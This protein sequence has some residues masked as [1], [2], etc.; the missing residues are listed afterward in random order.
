[1]VADL[2]GREKFVQEAV[3][4]AQSAFDDAD[5]AHGKTKTGLEATRKEAMAAHRLADLLR[6]SEELAAVQERLRKAEAADQNSTN[7]MA[8]A[9]ASS[10]TST[11][12][13][14]LRCLDSNAREEA[15]QLNAVATLLELTPDE[16]RG[17]AIQGEAIEAD[18]ITLIEPT[19]IDLEGYGAIRVTPGGEDLSSRREAAEAAKTRLKLELDRHG[20]AGV[21]DAVGQAN[22]REAWLN[23]AAIHRTTV[24]AHA[25]EG[26][27]ALRN[28]VATLEV[29]VGRIQEN[30]DD[31]EIPDITA[32]EAAG[33]ADELAQKLKDVET[34]EREASD[35]LKDAEGTLQTKK[36]LHSSA[37]S[38]RDLAE[39]RA[40][41][42]RDALH[43]AANEDKDEDLEQALHDATEAQQAAS[44]EVDKVETALVESDPD[45]ARRELEAADEARDK[46]EANFR[47][48]RQM[49]RDLETELRAV[50][51]DDMAAEIEVAEGDLTRAKVL[52]ARLNHEGEA[53]TLLQNTLVEEEQIARETFLTPVRDRIKPYLKRLFPG[54]EL[55]LDDQTLKITH[56]RREGQDEPY[57]QLSIGTRE[58]LAVLA[59]LA[60]AD[61]LD[62]HGKKSPIILD[63]ALVFSD[64]QRFEE[65]Q[66]IL[67]RAAERLQILVLTCHERAYFDRGWTT[68]RLQNSKRGV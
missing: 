38:Q 52:E 22:D 24:E 26:L 36:N 67:D 14:E 21:Q 44:A 53:L 3:N 62:E 34:A 51:K 8:K 20:V 41:D 6:K 65:M 10:F 1:M 18:A 45:G 50:G 61:L 15:A 9:K 46:V 40:K 39:G 25:V 33:C 48:G 63:D 12:I 57:E 42:L 55:M 29:E 11:A 23:E 58:Q 35:A 32:E 68:R 31:S 60:F 16:G 56:L 54:S 19:Q 5:G 47:E 2:K 17:A 27:D 7:L 13:E 30:I 28:D 43:E 4:G 59:R 37:T 64:D 66:R 49:V